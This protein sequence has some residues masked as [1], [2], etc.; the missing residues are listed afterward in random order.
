MLWV[1][2][3]ITNDILAKNGYMATVELEG[4]GNSLVVIMSFQLIFDFLEQKEENSYEEAI[5]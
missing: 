3:Q 2:C 5:H 1:E 4:E